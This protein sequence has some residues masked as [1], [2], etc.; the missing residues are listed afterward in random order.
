MQKEVLFE[1]TKDHLETGM[2][3]YPVG[4]C[5]TSNVDE[6]IGLKYVNHPVSE[7]INQDPIEVIYLLYYKKFGSV[8]EVKNFKKLLNQRATL[9][10]ETIDA[11][12]K[13]PKKGKPMELF[14]IALQILGIFEKQD[15]YREDCLNIIAKLPI[16]TALIINHHAGWSTNFKND[17]NKGYMENFTDM[18][19]IPDK[20]DVLLKEILKI[21]NLLHY[22]HGGGNLSVFVG[23]AVASSLSDMYSSLSAAMNALS[24]SRHGRANQDCLKFVQD[25]KNKIGNNPSFEDLKALIIDKIKKHELI[26]GFGHAVLKV[27]DPRATIFYEFAK[28]HFSNDSLACLALMLR[29]VVPEILKQNTKINDPYPNIDAISGI[30][31]SASG[32]KYSE[33][34]TILFGLARCVGIAIQIV[35]ERCEARDKKGTPIIRPRYIFKN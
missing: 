10:N 2:R 6:K 30:V 9:S 4:Y 11:I 26:Y 14:S 12:L 18:L 7:M 33:Y 17:P 31:L 20:D 35:Y 13:L 29:D 28:T 21:F 23:K 27:E 24:G 22:D 16:I 34:Y 3:G 5:T 19:N 32:F 1:I 15:D 8:D 25:I